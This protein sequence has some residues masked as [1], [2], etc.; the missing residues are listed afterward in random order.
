MVVLGYECRERL[1]VCYTHRYLLVS[2][3]HEE[4][5][6]FAK[7]NYMIQVFFF[8]KLKKLKKTWKKKIDQQ[9]QSFFMID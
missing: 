4:P 2:I 9:A 8:K 1:I 3:T 6:P 7:L 5:C